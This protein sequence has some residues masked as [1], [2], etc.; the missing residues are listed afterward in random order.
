MIFQAANS[1][2]RRLLRQK[3]IIN[4]ILLIDFF[5]R[6]QRIVAVINS[7]AFGVPQ[8][9]GIPPQDAHTGRVK[10]ACRNFACIGGPQHCFK[11]RTQLPRRLVGKGDREDL[12]RFYRTDRQQ[13]QQFFTGPSAGFQQGLQFFYFF[14]R[15]GAKHTVTVVRRAKPYQVGN[16]V[17]QHCGLTAACTC[18]DQQGAIHRKNR[19]L[20]H[21]VELAKTL[22][23]YLLTQ[24]TKPFFQ[25][26]AHLTPP[27]LFSYHP[28]I[29]Y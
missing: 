16:A 1:R 20:L 2:K 9:L 19:V 26:T 12:P 11:P 25:F 4:I 5:H 21:R 14:L 13:G 6:P 17:D 22:L 7:K 15:Y 8:P 10:R 28:R 24:G 18:Q 23:N 29:L 3:F 27:K